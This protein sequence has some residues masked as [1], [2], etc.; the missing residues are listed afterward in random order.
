[1][2]FLFQSLRG[3]RANRDGFVLPTVIFTMVILGL[4]GVAA[5]STANDEHRSSRAMR[6]SGA[7]L[8][9]AEAGASW[10]LRTQVA[11]TKTVLD[12]LYASMA[13]G[14][15]VDLGVS[16]LP[17][18]ASYHGMFYREDAGGAGLYL[19]TVEAR[20]AGPWGG[21]HT[22]TLALSESGGIPITAA[23]KAIAEV[24][25][26]D[27]SILGTDAVPPGWGPMCSGALNDVPGI[28]WTGDLDVN[29]LSVVTGDPPIVHDPTITLTNMFEWG[30]LN[31][32]SLVAMA[33]ITLNGDL[34]TIG[35]SVT[36]GP[37]P[38]CDT[39][40]PWNWGAPK[41]PGHP[42]HDYFPIIH[43][44]NIEIENGGSGQGI[45]IV[46]GELE[47]EG[48]PFEWYGIIINQ[49]EIEI[50]DNI[51]V[52]GAILMNGQIE[53]E[54]NPVIQYS[55]CAIDRAQRAQG[56]RSISLIGSRAWSS[57]L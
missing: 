19:L 8:Y 14:D 47:I 44:T 45:L 1:M 26:D 57:R 56:L 27:A 38:Q 54:D 30:D 7:A 23:L 17:S 52:Y 33:D 35:P 2:N 46:D 21:Q 13:P 34:A 24:E 22:V 6:E 39:S 18:G 50:E 43:A 49:D 32:D 20:G 40:D 42:C 51:T 12:T 5:L 55:Q 31:R 15:S 3:G 10:I 25:R 41:L 9:A 11:G 48:L 28:T 53:I 37:P 29:P 4:I 36:G 16:A